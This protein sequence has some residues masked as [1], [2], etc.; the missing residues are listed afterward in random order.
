MTN[1]A[2]R[3]RRLSMGDVVRH[4]V[5]GKHYIVHGWH[6]RPDGKVMFYKCHHISDR[7]IENTFLPNQLETLTK[8]EKDA[9]TRKMKAGNYEAVSVPRARRRRQA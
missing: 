8:A 7:L 4:R 9:L 3:G 2:L 6:L 5:T 1:V